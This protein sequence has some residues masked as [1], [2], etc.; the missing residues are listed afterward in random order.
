MGR[1]AAVRGE[2]AGEEHA[3]RGLRPAASVCGVRARVP[4]AG[5][6]VGVPPHPTGTPHALHY[7]GDCAAAAV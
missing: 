3:W 5:R 1:E 4:A 2:Q 6:V 7:A